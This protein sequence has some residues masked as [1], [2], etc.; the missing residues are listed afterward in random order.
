MLLSHGVV[1]PDD[2]REARPRG[3]GGPG[4]VVGER[5]RLDRRLGEGTFG[6]VWVALDGATNDE[7]ALK[8]LRPELVNDKR[9]MARFEREAEILMELNHPHIARALDSGNVQPRPYIAMPLIRGQTLG[10]RMKA[11]M[12]SGAHL[13]LEQ[14]FEWTRQIASALDYAHAIGVVHRDLKPGN[15]MVTDRGAKVLDFGIARLVFESDVERQTTVG[16][17]L[18]TMYYLSPEQA[19]GE[20]A[21]PPSDLFSLGTLVFQMLTSHVAWAHDENHRALAIGLPAPSKVNSIIAVLERIRTA[22]RPRPTAYRSDLPVAVD[23]VIQKSLAAVA[24]DRYESGADF[25]EALEGAFGDRTAIATYTAVVDPAPSPTQTKTVTPEEEP[26]PTR[27]VTRPMPT[28]TEAIE[29]T[30]PFPTEAHAGD[31]S[32]KYMIGG[33]LLLAAAAV[34]IAIGT[35]IGGPAPTPVEP[36]AVARPAPSVTAAPSVVARPAPDEPPPP[37]APAPKERPAPKRTAAKRAPPPP[38]PAPE[39]AGRHRLLIMLDDA[40]AH[41]ED[42]ERFG[43]VETAIRRLA[44]ELPAGPERRAIERCTATAAIAADL[45]DLGAC[46]RR[47]L[48]ARKTP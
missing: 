15:I 47:L 11:A 41:P 6:E 10:E 40:A 36:A 24:G 34:V 17:I 16:R 33:A 43:R 5:Y 13:P 14:V 46:A 48:R 42:A 12:Q 23:P 8:L 27:S 29:A 35:N 9:M 32:T 28:P 38:T 22:P 19:Q 26:E 30:P 44:K 7:V 45:T 2:S 21:G 18:G 37:E 31:G 20:R 1:H 25:V 3:L 39:P 4:D